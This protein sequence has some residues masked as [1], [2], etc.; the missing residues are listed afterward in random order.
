MDNIRKQASTHNILCYQETGL[1]AGDTSAFRQ[2][3]FLSKWYTSYNNGS[4]G[5]HGVAT[6]VSPSISKEYEI[7]TIM[8]PMGQVLLTSLAPKGDDPHR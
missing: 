7:S 4:Q 8:G 5:H 6:C 1:R 3:G 2:P